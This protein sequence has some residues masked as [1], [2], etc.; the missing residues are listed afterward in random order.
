MDSNR[1]RPAR[2]SPRLQGYDYAQAGAY[3]VT[4]CT[5]NRLERFGVIVDG[6]MQL[7]ALGGIAEEEWFQ[8]A[9]LRPNVEL[10]AFVVMPNHVHGIIVIHDTRDSVGTGRA[11]SLQ[12]ST[13]AS[14][15]HTSAGKSVSGSLPAIVGAYKSAVTKRVNRIQNI[16]AFPL[17]QG[18]YHDHIIRNEADLNRIREYVVNNSARWQEDVFYGVE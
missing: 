18:R 12:P 15:E 16:S 13:P 11:L 9:S 3:F 8:T 14:S 10:D 17:W 7:N 6:M 4:I 1:E 5:H 2:R